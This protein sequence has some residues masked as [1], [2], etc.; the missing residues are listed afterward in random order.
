MLC[1]ES[2]GCAAKVR[3]RGPGLGR[4][5]YLTPSL[6]GRQ[7]TLQCLNFS[8]NKIRKTA[9]II[10]ETL[11][12]LSLN[13]F[14][15][16]CSFISSVLIMARLAVLFLLKY[17]HFTFRNTYSSLQRTESIF[18]EIHKMFN[19]S[20]M[21]WWRNLTQTSHSFI[22]KPVWN[23]RQRMYFTHTHTHTHGY[24]QHY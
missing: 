20:L 16:F 3:M 10:F 14:Y 17:L 23:E 1:D 7:I 13:D 22:P 9:W 2:H 21:Y 4:G 11:L 15:S 18:E 8:P 6:W 24:G 19:K 12:I 5:I